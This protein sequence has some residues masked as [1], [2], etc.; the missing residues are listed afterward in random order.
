MIIKSFTGESAA[1]ALKKVRSEMGGDAVI[2]KTRR[3]ADSADGNVIEVTAC[4]DKASVGQ[5]SRVLAE[6]TTN[7]SESTVLP[8]TPSEDTSSVSAQAQL[9]NEVNA[10]LDRMEKR[11]ADVAGASQKAMTAQ[12][13]AMLKELAAKSVSGRP[14]SDLD[15]ALWRLERSLMDADVPETFTTLLLTSVQQEDL[16]GST[17]A[18]NAR[19]LLVDL[20]ADMMVPSMELQA[21]DSVMVVGPSGAGKTSLIGKLAAHLITV[22]KKK[23]RLLSLDSTKVGA[24]D[25]VASWAEALGIPTETPLLDEQVSITPDETVITLIDTPGL[26]ADEDQLRSYIQLLESIEASHRLAVFPALMRT[27]DM[28]SMA[29]RLRVLNPT[30]VALTMLDMTS[31]HGSIIAGCESLGCKLVYTT[32]GPGGLGKLGTPNP[33]RTA[34]L[35]IPTLEDEHE[36]A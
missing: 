2:L 35:L 21:G 27:S 18:E 22:G 26:P 32:D 5:S 31:R 9:V 12:M 34:A 24:H 3:L 8:K 23:V 1:A 15:E 36:Q 11:L 7:T 29:T 19:R 28:E 13:A 25:E 14:D 20:L 30:H 4:L 16:N 33:A 17:P 6:G 10:R